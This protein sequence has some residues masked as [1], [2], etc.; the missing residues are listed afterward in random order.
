MRQL[1]SRTIHRQRRGRVADWH[2]HGPSGTS[3]R[4]TKASRRGR[5]LRL[6]FRL[7]RRHR[8]TLYACKEPPIPVM[9]A[10]GERCSKKDASIFSPRPAHRGLL[11]C[12]P[13]CLVWYG[14]GFVKVSRF[15]LSHHHCNNI[16]HRN[17]CSSSRAGG[18]WPEPSAENS[19]SYW[20]YPPPTN[21][22]EVQMLHQ[23]LKRHRRSGLPQLLPAS[24]LHR[25]QT[26]RLCF[27]VQFYTP[28]QSTPL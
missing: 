7:G 5:K 13:P 28:T 23:E 25:G 4:D 1:A 19:T 2:V 3:R 21:E 27:L 18:E 6:P 14:S 8:H 9:G 17:S 24:Y 11:R 20:Y 16:P 10:G 22:R 26:P 12:Y 15:P